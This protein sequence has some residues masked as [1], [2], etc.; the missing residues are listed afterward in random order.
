VL[1]HLSNAVA[2]AK[3]LIRRGSG[4]TGAMPP[5]VARPYYRGRM[6]ARARFRYAATETNG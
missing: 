6:G 5:K 3:T 4:T 2:V 1:S